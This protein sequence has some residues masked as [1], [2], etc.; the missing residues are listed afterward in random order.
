MMTGEL[1]LK[2]SSTERSGDNIG[3]G[4]VWSATT[5]SGPPPHPHR[6]HHAPRHRTP[7]YD[8]NT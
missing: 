5:N 6:H 8:L 7:D 1:M 2:L 3:G 4:D